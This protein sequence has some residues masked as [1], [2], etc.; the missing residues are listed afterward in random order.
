MRAFRGAVAL[1]ALA[2]LIS[3]TEAMAAVIQNSG[4]SLTVVEPNKWYDGPEMLFGSAA[5]ITNTTYTI[6]ASPAPYTLTTNSV[7]SMSRPVLRCRI[8]RAR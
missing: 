5:V 4:G 3:M 1:S 6:S 7:R 8:C 2:L